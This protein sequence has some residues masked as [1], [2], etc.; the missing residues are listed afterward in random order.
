M[1]SKNIEFICISTSVKGS[2]SAEQ[3]PDKKLPFFCKGVALLH[4]GQKGSNTFLHLLNSA[5]FHYKFPIIENEIYNINKDEQLKFFS[6][7]RVFRLHL[8]C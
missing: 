7:A 4:V 1:L 3:V 2:Q 8:E 5:Y 6:H